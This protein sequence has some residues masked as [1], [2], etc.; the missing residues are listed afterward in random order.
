[1]SPDE[2]TLPPAHVELELQSPFAILVCVKLEGGLHCELEG[3]VHCPLTFDNPV[4]I[5]VTQNTVD[6]NK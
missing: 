4:S 5:A 1:M 3:I 2:G 6:N